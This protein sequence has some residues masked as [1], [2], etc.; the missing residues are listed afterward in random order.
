MWLTHGQIGA[1]A[2]LL[3]PETRRQKRITGTKVKPYTAPASCSPST[4]SPNVQALSFRS[5]RHDLSSSP[6]SA[7]SRFVV[8]RCAS[9]QASKQ[10]CTYTTCNCKLQ[11]IDRQIG[12]N[13]E[14]KKQGGN[15]WSSRRAKINRLS[16]SADNVH[17]SRG[18]EHACRESTRLLNINNASRGNTTRGNRSEKAI[19]LVGI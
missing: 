8:K 18:V 3:H 1:F 15:T 14:I 7:F 5:K 19:N 10:A 13:E 4:G 12:R 17:D 9:A 6:L 11:L 16:Q 2:G